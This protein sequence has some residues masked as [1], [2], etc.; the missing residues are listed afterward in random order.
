MKDITDIIMDNEG[1]IYSIA[2]KF[3]HYKSRDDLFQAGCI[4]MIKAYNNF[5]P[6]KEVKFTSY[7]YQYVFGEMRDLV[8]KD[9]NV[10]LNSDLMRLKTKV[11]KAK[12]ILTQ[13][14]KKIPTSKELSDYL[15]IDYKVIDQILNYSDSYSIDEVVKDDLSLHEIIPDKMSDMDI[16]VSLKWE[17]EKLKEPDKS[18]MQKKFFEDLTQSQIASN[19]GLSQVDVSRREK[20][21]LTKIRKSFN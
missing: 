2:N 18:I 14:L 7:A 6:S 3:S 8:Y 4:G 12:E 19:L 11:E 16:L 17:I 9:H 5:D 15:E 21:I 10:R 20:K 1:F 13:N